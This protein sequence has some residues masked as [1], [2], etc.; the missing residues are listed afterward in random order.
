MDGMNLAKLFLA[1]D[2]MPELKHAMSDEESVEVG[3]SE[4][5]D[6][7]CARPEIRAA[8]FGLA[9]SFGVIGFD[10]AAGTW[11]GTPEVMRFVPFTE[12]EI[13]GELGEPKKLQGLLTALMEKYERPADQFCLKVGLKV[14]ERRGQVVTKELKGWRGRSE[15]WYGLKESDFGS[16]AEKVQAARKPR[17]RVDHILD[18]L[19]NEGPTLSRDLVTGMSEFSRSSVYDRLAEARNAGLVT[20]N[21][22]GAWILTE[23]GE[24]RAKPKGMA[25]GQKSS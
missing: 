23:K 9:R 14:M 6:W 12:D 4:V 11:K 17:M 13:R 5:V 21:E 8:V 19:M 22:A 15:K 18:V 25:E 2:K 7:L 16:D 20:T 3:Q 24:L 10:A 1:A